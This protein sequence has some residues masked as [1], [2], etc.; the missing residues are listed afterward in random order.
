MYIRD[1]VV[2]SNG[3]KLIIKRYRPCTTNIC[4]DHSITATLLITTAMRKYYIH[5]WKIA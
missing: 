3:Y 4:I 1:T 2:N 5:T